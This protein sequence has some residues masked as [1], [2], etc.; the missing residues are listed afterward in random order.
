MEKYY[1]QQAFHKSIKST[2]LQAKVDAIFEK[3]RKITG[4][5]YNTSPLE[6]PT[7]KE[8]GECLTNREK[9]CIRTIHAEHNAI[10][11]AND[12]L[13]ESTLYV[14]HEPCEYYTKLLKQTRVEK[15]VYGKNYPNPYNH[16]FT[17][18]IEIRQYKNETRIGRILDKS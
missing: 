7:C 9:R 2:C 6:M 13:W 16:H 14:T 11:H 15:I 1:I 12:S 3:N 17:K 8:I 18:G 5:R 10:F 4:E